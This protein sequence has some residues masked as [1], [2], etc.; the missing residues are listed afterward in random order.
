MS[1]F[2]KYAD[3]NRRCD[4]GAE[5]TLYPPTAGGGFAGAFCARHSP[6]RPGKVV[7]LYHPVG[8]ATAATWPYEPPGPARSANGP[9]PAPPVATGRPQPRRGRASE[10]V[11]EILRGVPDRIEAFRRWN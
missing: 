8:R 4:C 1:K 5:A 6:G 3:E 2:M 9:T 7:E 11:M 10:A